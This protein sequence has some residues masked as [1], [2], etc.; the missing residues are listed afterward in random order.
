MPVAVWASVLDEPV[1]GSLR[2]KH[3][4]QRL[5]NDKSLTGYVILDKN[6]DKRLS[7]VTDGIISTSDSGI[8]DATQVKVFDLAKSVIETRQGKVLVVLESLL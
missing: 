3:L 8:I 6:P 5:M 1:P 7:N 4:I 2:H